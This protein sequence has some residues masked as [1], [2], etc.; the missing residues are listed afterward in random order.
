MKLII[1][2][3]PLFGVLA[4]AFVFI[5]NSWVS[6]QEVGEPKMARIAKNIADGVK[7]I[8]YTKKLNSLKTLK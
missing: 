6:K 3:L 7:A 4:L 5:K 1:D 8:H 2:F